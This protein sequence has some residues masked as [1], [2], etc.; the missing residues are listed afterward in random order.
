MPSSERAKHPK[1]EPAASHPCLT[2]ELVASLKSTNLRL[3]LLQA[4]EHLCNKSDTPSVGTRADSMRYSGLQ[5]DVLALYRKCLRESRKK[6]AVSA[7]DGD[8]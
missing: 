6:P 4:F 1:L 2:S 3:F 5:R 8:F 7:V